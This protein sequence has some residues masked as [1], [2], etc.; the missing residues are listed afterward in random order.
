MTWRFVGIATWAVLALAG[1]GS[2][3]IMLVNPTTGAAARCDA[4]V[5][6]YFNP[7]AA[8]ETCAKG[9]ESVGFKRVGSY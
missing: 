4:S 7:A 5:N 1:C 3:E 8:A 9:F 6:D 2:T